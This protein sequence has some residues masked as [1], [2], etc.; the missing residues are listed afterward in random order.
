MRG[1]VKLGKPRKNISAT[2]VR[3]FYANARK[4]PDVENSHE[5]RTFV[6]G[7]SFGFS[8]ERIRAILELRGPL[9]SETSFNVRKLRANRDSDAILRDICVEGAVW[10]TGAHMNP[11]KLRRQDLTPLA[12]VTIKRAVLIHCI[13]TGQEV[14]V[15]EIIED[16]MTSII[17]KL[18]L[19]KPPLAFL[20][21]IAR[22]LE[23][24]GVYYNALDS[25]DKV[26]KGRPI[27]AEVMENI[28]HPQHHSA[29]PHQ[30]PQLHQFHEQPFSPSPQYQS[31]HHFEQEQ[32]A[33]EA[34]FEAAY[35]PQ[36]Y[37]WGQLHEDMTTLKANQQEFYDSILAQQAQYGLRLT[38][39]ETRQNTM[40]AEQHK[41]HQEMREYHE[42]Q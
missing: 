39:I 8:K 14:E 36:N 31:Q 18:H 6:R 17:S 32:P 23:E 3:E 1:C 26:P 16:T 37:G 35:G 11:L 9:D 15:E 4:N 38:D 12:R 29:P 30:S 21:V 2:L 42:Q 40:W 10:E 25:D 5:F 33:G 19:S 27:T 22:L 13:I 34:T 28:R 41:F 20:N 24:S 7:V